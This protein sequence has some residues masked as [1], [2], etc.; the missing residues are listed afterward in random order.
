LNEHPL[1]PGLSSPWMQYGYCV[2]VWAEQGPANPN[3][4]IVS[5]TIKIPR[6]THSIGQ[7]GLSIYQ[8]QNR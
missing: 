7:I 1:Q 4:T 6:I 8:P 5:N 2:A 3:P